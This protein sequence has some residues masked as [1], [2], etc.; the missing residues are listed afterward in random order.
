MPQTLDFLLRAL[1]VGAG[2][3]AIMD[4]VAM[5]RQR[6]AGTPMPDYGLV[7]RWLAY[8][9]RG[10]FHHRAIAASP[11]VQ[12]EKLIGW[13][14]HYLIGIGFA[15]LLLAIFADWADHPTPMPALIVGIGS[16]AAPF[17]LMQPGMGS[18]LFARKTPRPGTARLRSLVTH[19]TFAC[20]LY[21]A[22][23]A[24]SLLPP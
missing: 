4:I 8:M 24:Q 18:G 12:G 19:I 14:A 6:L 21:L 16:V 9:P 20:G 15:G 17:L 5:L 11:A 1:L 13:T 22:G 3:T 7:G 10:R 23:M 2:A